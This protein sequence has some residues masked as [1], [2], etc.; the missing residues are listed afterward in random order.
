MRSTDGEHIS[1]RLSHLSVCPTLTFSPQ[2][3]TKLG[4]DC[5]RNFPQL[6]QSGA[7][8]VEGRCADAS[9]SGQ[10]SIDFESVAFCSTAWSQQPAGTAPPPRR[11]RTLHSRRRLSEA[12]MYGPRSL[13]RDGRSAG[14]IAGGDAQYQWRRTLPGRRQSFL[15]VMQVH[16]HCIERQI[17]T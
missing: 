15:S 8:L 2:V 16:T 5:R 12:C 14:S 4:H 17:T 1:V 9:R 11:S 7:L 10:F 3:R 6:T 13:P